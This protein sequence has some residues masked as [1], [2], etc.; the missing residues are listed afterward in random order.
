[1][2]LNVGKKER[3]EQVTAIRENPFQERAEKKKKKVKVGVPH[4][5][6]AGGRDKSH[7]RNERDDVEGKE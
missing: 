7:S 4:M 5:R 3:E 1:V 2:G 6:P